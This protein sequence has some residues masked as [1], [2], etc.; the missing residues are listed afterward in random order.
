M[1]PSV[2]FDE[3]NQHQK[4]KRTRVT[5]SLSD[6]FIEDLPREDSKVKFSEKSDGFVKD[7]RAESDGF[8]RDD[9][10]K[11]Q[12]K[13]N[14]KNKN[15][16][17]E[18]LLALKNTET[19]QI[20]YITKDQYIKYKEKKRN[21]KKNLKQIAKYTKDSKNEKDR[22]KKRIIITINFNFHR[23]GEYD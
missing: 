7:D 13:L 4:H 10:M 8:F 15:K 5:H 20:K 1:I 11:M 6:V 16:N 3:H 12:M 18:H 19:G 17:K 9:N 21:K 2:T 22:N 23:K 14:Y